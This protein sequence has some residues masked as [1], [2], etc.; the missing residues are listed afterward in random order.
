MA[1]VSRG[2]LVRAVWRWHFWAGLLVLPVLAWLAV[3]GSLYLYKAEIERAFYAEWMASAPGDPLPLGALARRV[4]ASTGAAVTQIARPAA[5]GESWRLTLA[6]PGGDRKTAFVDPT[7]ASVLGITDAGG[8][9]A[10]VRTLHSLVITGPIGNAVV[11]IVAG[12]TIILVATGIYLWWPRGVN[13]AV[14]LRGSPRKRQFWR[15][16][17]AST[18][19]IAGVVILFLAITGMPWSGVWGKG[20]QTIVAAQGIGRPLSPGASS[21]ADHGDHHMA[22]QTLPWSMQQA[23][24]PHGGPRRIGPDEALTAASARGLGHAWTLSF[25]AAPGAPFLF[26]A[27]VT[28]AQEARVIYVDAGDGRILQDARYGDFGWGAQA[29]E[30]GIL[31][32]QGQQYGEVNR[33]VMLGGCIAILLL[34]ISAPVMWL[35]RRPA[36]RIG[37]PPGHGGRGLVAIML[38]AGIAFP[39]TGLTMIAAWAIGAA[40]RRLR[41]SVAAGAAT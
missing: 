23:A 37:A 9:M 34:C 16:L 5:A 21:K 7:N 11:E 22:R 18:G 15:D 1:Q 41:P 6:M 4:E 29:I 24:M 31:T 8:I 38:A 2:N 14:A 3:T 39:L 10:T 25:P 12:W 17:H 19:L 35:K 40:A 30:W 32:H 27:I 20:L 28:R 36:G 13:R 26:S 33:L